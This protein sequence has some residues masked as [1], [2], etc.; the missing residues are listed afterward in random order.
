MKTIVACAIIPL[1]VL[2]QSAAAETGNAPFCLQTAT[3]AKCVYDT[4]GECERARGDTSAVQCIT[5]SDAH[6]VTGLGDPVPLPVTPISPG[7]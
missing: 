6:G 3:G 4:M 1:S 5:Q 2:L 7:R